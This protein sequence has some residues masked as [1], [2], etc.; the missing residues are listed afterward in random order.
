MRNRVFD[1]LNGAKFIT[2]IGGEEASIAMSRLMSGVMEF[3]GENWVDALSEGQT[4]SKQWLMD[5]IISTWG[6]DAFRRTTMVGGWVGM[7][8]LVVSAHGIP[9]DEWHSVD[10]SEEA[11]RAA[12]ILNPVNLVAHT[13]DMMDYQYT[14]GDLIIN[15]SGEHIPDVGAWL[16]LLPSG[17]RVVVQSNNMFGIDGHVNCVDSEDQLFSKVKDYLDVNLLS[18]LP[19]PWHGWKRFMVIGVRR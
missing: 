6:K 5:S 17:C 19:L 7:L 2:K 15:T 3:P 13:T 16:S 11:N 4:S 9:I 18:T 10:L 12:T 8:P 14:D 1:V